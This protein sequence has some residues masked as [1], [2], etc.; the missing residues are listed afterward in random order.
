MDISGVAGQLSKWK[1]AM[2][3]AGML[4]GTRAAAS[5]HCTRGSYSHLQFTF[6]KEVGRI[7]KNGKNK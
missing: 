1:A 4:R 6:V 3:R 5:L 7:I 2:G